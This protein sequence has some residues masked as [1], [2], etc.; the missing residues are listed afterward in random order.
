M[1]KIHRNKRGF[2]IIELTVVMIVI[3]AILSAIL[4]SGQS[5]ANAGRVTSALASVKAL[6]TAAIAYFNNNGGSYS[7]LSLSNLASSSYLP[8]NFTTGTNSNPWNGNITVAPDTNAAYFDITFTN[9]PSAAA[10]SLTNAV[11]KLSQS[12]PTYAAA[13]GT[14]TAAF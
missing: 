12:A 2:T 8:A 11:S 6:Q 14:W 10:T 13:T 5:T 3:A 7:G 1:K 9:V 4:F